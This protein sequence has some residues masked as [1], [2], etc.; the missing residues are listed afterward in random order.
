MSWQ[1]GPR[2]FV[3]PYEVTLALLRD[4]V[5]DSEDSDV[6]GT[7]VV[8]TL[9][10]VRP[11]KVVQIR[12]DG[13][14]TVGGGFI[15]ASVMTYRVW[16]TT[17]A[18]AQAL[19]QFIR[20]AFLNAPPSVDGATVVEVVDVLGPIDVVDP[21]DQATITYFGRVELWLRP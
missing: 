12:R 7:T 5:A 21:D 8:R 15:D 11:T 10:K 19:A 17:P 18:K 16:H 20:S 9:P 1:R 2:E 13:G 14:R 3:D 4:A 6:T